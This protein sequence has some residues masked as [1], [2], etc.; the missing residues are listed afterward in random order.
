MCKSNK[1]VDCGKAE[2]SLATV[3]IVFKNPRGINEPNRNLSFRSQ[4]SSDFVC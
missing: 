3:W 2:Q 4:K 1:A